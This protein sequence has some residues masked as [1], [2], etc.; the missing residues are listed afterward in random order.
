MPSEALGANKWGFAIP[1][2]PVLFTLVAAA[3]VWGLFPGLWPATCQAWASWCERVGQGWLWGIPAW[4]LCELPSTVHSLE[5]VDT[6]LVQLGV[7]GHWV[8]GMCIWYQGGDGSM[9]QDS[10]RRAAGA[11]EWGAERE[12][13][14]SSAQYQWGQWPTCSRFTQTSL[15]LSLH[16]I[17]VRRSS[18][19]DT[20]LKAFQRASLSCQSMHALKA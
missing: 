19:M 9:G 17:L 20:M 1:K 4:V 13:N 11:A 14:V 12:K 16:T 2:G 8:E 5:P 15:E 10:S 7:Q 3:A 6:C 18:F